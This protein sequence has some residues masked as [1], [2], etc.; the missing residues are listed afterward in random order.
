MSRKYV[1]KLS[2]P[3]T[4]WQNDLEQL[5][6]AN[7]SGSRNRNARRGSS[8]FPIWTLVEP[9]VPGNWKKDL[10]LGRSAVR[11]RRYG[12]VSNRSASSVSCGNS[13]RNSLRD[14]IKPSSRRLRL[15]RRS[16]YYDLR[17]QA[18]L[19]PRSLS[20]RVIINTPSLKSFNIATRPAADPRKLSRSLFEP[21]SSRV[22]D[23]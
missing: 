16:C 4:R 9:F 14:R 2:N 18:R 23:P 21:I 5:V 3:A 12:L 15:L 8:P 1:I 7:R 17:L 6:P 20:I 22:P 11:I 13:S 19:P 10:T